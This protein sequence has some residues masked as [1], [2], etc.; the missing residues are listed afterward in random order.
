MGIKLKI[1]ADWSVER[2]EQF[3]QQKGSRIF[4]NA[5]RHNHTIV[6]K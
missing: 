3:K 2:V 4:T 1:V 5:K 6:L